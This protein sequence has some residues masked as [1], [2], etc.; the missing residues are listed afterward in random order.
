MQ[1]E[2][3][4]VELLRKCLE[5]F[6]EI[7]N[8]SLNLKSGRTN[9]YAIASQIDKFFQK[10]DKEAFTPENDLNVGIA[11]FSDG[12]V[13]KET[14]EYLEGF[15]SYSDIDLDEH[16]Y[17]IAAAYDAL[18]LESENEVVIAEVTDLYEKA[19]QIKRIDASYIRFIS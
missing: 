15:R 4:A 19:A 6:N 8:K 3:T 17:S 12:D 11:S 1:T 5:A 14:R 16:L 2:T 7:P 13:S 10:L 9:T 18:N